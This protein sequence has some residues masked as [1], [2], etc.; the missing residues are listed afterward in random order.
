MRSR[1]PD[2]PTDREA[3]RVDGDGSRFCAL[4][5]H[6]PSDTP[7]GAELQ[8]H[9]ICA[10]LQDRGY[11]T[12]YVAYRS[13]HT[14][15]VSRDGV[16]VVRLDTDGGYSSAKHVID[17]IA[18][19]DPDVLYIRILKDL[20]IGI[21]AARKTG[22]HL[23]FNVSHDA[24][25]LGRFADWPGKATP[26]PIHGGYRRLKLAAL[27]SL[28]SVPD[29]VFAQTETQQRLLQENRGRHAT[30]TG[31][32]HPIPECDPEKEDPP[33]VLWLASLKP[34]KQPHAFVDLAESCQ[35]LDCEFWLVGQPTDR[36]LADEIDGR[37]ADV[38]NCTYLGGCSVAQSNDYIGRAS[39]FVNTS[40]QEGFPNTFIQAW[41]RKT[42]VVSLHADPLDQAA[43][44]ALGA[45]G[46][47]DRDRLEQRV[48]EL[49]SNGGQRARTATHAYE[50]ACREHS[51]AAVVDR[52]EAALPERVRV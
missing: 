51:I 23:A 32:G 11:E 15:V 16:R 44:G 38:P 25:C 14:D 50:Y 7:G 17:R 48:R 33:V 12:E 22:A 45:Y 39:L 28:L 43:D 49:V 4:L 1:R 30:L 5:G 13:A 31:N 34:W 19:I 10:E 26:T 46:L 18:A 21:A 29:T 42:P 6:H 40:T 35:D 2:R 3:L 47:G 20:P 41:L 52:I 36:T 8:A 37:V 24:H 27:R 9:L